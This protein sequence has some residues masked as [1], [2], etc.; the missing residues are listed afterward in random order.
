MICKP[1][2][3]QRKRVNC[4]DLL[5]DF[6]L[7]P[8]PQKVSSRPFTLKLL[9]KPKSIILI[10]LFSSS[11]RFYVGLTCISFRTYLW[12]QVTVNYGILVAIVN[13]A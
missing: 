5:G 13:G 10:D 1:F 7:S 4:I 2:R 9:P 6:E 8:Y 12:L 11:S 3:E